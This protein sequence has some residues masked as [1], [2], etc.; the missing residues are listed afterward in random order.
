M[1]VFKVQPAD[2]RVKYVLSSVSVLQ[3]CDTFVT[4]TAIRLF[5]N[6]DDAVVNNN[7]RNVSPSK[8]DVVFI[9]E[10]IP[11]CVVRKGCDPICVQVMSAASGA[12]D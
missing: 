5:R 2:R 12:C 3:R 11:N 8:L 4:S 9:D 10:L 1:N 7:H 6:V